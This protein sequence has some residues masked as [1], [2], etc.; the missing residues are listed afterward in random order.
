MR[1]IFLEMCAFGPYAGVETVDFSAIGSGLYLITGDTGAGKTTIFDAVTFALYG[2]ASGETRSP[3]TLRSDYASAAV[4]TYVR[5]DFECGGK[6]YSVRR[7]PSYLKPKRGG[8]TTSSQPSAELI[9]PDGGIKTGVNEVTAEIR[10]ILGLDFGQFSQ[11]AMI[12][13]GEFR[14]LLSAGTAERGKI[15]QKLF[16]TAAYQ[17][18]QLRLKEEVSALKAETE[19][20]KKRI[21][22]TAASVRLPEEAMGAFKAD[23][24]SALEG[25]ESLEEQNRLDEAREEELSELEKAARA[26]SSELAAKAA[27]AQRGE[28]LRA[29]LSQAEKA[30][31]RA[32]TESEN[33]ESLRRAVSAAEKAEAKVRPAEEKA[34]REENALSELNA[35]MAK[36]LSD[37]ASARKRQEDAGQK[38]AELEK[39]EP[40][41]A[42]LSAKITSLR[43]S[44]EAYAPI[45]DLKKELSLNAGLRDDTKRK[46]EAA[47]AEK[48]ERIRRLEEIRE[49]LSLLSG[50][51][52][53]A[54]SAAVTLEALNRRLEEAKEG[55]KE[56]ERYALLLSYL[57]VIREN[58]LALDGELR[59][60]SA[61]LTEAESAFMRARAGILASGLREG[62]PCPVCGSKEH[63][64]PAELPPEAP[65]EEELEALRAHA[66]ECREKYSAESE[67]AAA[68]GASA[69][70]TEK[71]LGKTLLE[72]TG[73]D[74]LRP[75]AFAELRKAVT[76]QVKEAGSALAEA[77]RRAKKLRDLQAELSAPEKEDPVPALE[78]ELAGAESRAELLGEKIRSLS[79]SLLFP[80]RSDA[81]R[82][83]SELESRLA[84]GQAE[85]KRAAEAEKAASAEVSALEALLSDR[86]ERIPAAEKARDT[87]REA[88]LAALMDCGFASAA[89]YSA[90]RMDAHS[91]DAAKTKLE[92]VKLGLA[93]AEER[94]KNARAAAE[95]APEGDASAIAEEMKA[96][97]RRAQNFSEEARAVFSRLESNRACLAS[98]RVLGK[99]LSAA[100]EKLSMMT[101]LS[102]TAS[103]ELQGRARISFEQYVQTAYFE[104]VIAAANIRLTAMSGGRYLLL[105]RE[106]PTDQRSKSGLDLDIL[107]HYTGRSRSVDTLSGGEAFEASLAMALG[108]SD[109]VQRFSGGVRLDAMFVDEGF[110]TLDDERLERA[111]GML[112]QLA[113]GDRQ[114]GIISHVAQLR[115]AIG[116]KLVITRSP[117]GSHARL[118]LE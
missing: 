54:A 51:D 113:S 116:K 16:G 36:V 49:E 4:K 82:A 30:L 37:L 14:R 114:V 41:R 93:A 72:L 13:Q 88:F 73:N 38:L 34:E 57:S 2:Q 101:G 69:G 81:E 112:L 109:V 22:T 61:D 44:L 85:L 15:F 94:L 97:E 32:E 92:Q 79:A 80:T 96:E 56:E 63:P 90:A 118:E 107:D 68:L 42:E 5:L 20:L 55:E 35:S 78:L 27:L 108:L 60:A 58:C 67:K 102:Q 99:K 47:R 115:Q 111:V 98:L 24:Y 106:V 12:A 46:L 74:E 50:A 105:R 11:I 95:N 103:G 25:L 71:K 62:E 17:S 86:R 52:E 66:E 117:T 45:E 76:L 28:A 75:G 6:T 19:E 77:R 59:K 29:E 91:L 21:I 8:G 33:A 48:L 65:S 89:E 9:M 10:D 110:G 40:E 53:E 7:S 31:E 104:R 100:S 43:D 23:A 26:A 3:S 83:A 70:E 87:S 84:H 39:K 18:F 1:P 64:F